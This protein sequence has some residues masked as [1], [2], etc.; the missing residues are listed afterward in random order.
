[1]LW[2]SVDVVVGQDA[3]RGAIEI[4]V[5]AALDRPHE[6]GEADQAEH[7]RDGDEVEK[8][9]HDTNSAA[10]TLADGTLADGTLAVSHDRWAAP[11]AS[12]SVGMEN[13]ARSALS[14]TRIEEPDM[15]TAAI[16]GVTKPATAIG[17]ASAL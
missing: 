10:G 16:N 3:N 14:V 1:M 12:G 11:S 5:L 8:H 15:A 9:I 2:T 6:G 7:E 17:T 4:L 13:R